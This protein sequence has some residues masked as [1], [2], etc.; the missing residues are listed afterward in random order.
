MQG[1]ARLLYFL[2]YDNDIRPVSVLWHEWDI[3]AAAVLSLFLLLLIESERTGR[4]TEE[5]SSTELNKIDNH[6][7]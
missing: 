3:Y 2:Q 5:V 6:Y 7:Q 1:I 4:K